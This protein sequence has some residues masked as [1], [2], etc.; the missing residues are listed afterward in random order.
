MSFFS[1]RR[2]QKK[3]IEC[4]VPCDGRGK[5]VCSLQYVGTVICL[6]DTWLSNV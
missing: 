3:S 6:L 4:V 5:F 2:D 1:F